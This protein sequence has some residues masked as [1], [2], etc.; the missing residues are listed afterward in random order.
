[1]IMVSPPA[2]VAMEVSRGIQL[3]V[4]RFIRDLLHI[5]PLISGRFGLARRFA[6]AWMLVLAGGPVVAQS[7][8]PNFDS[9]AYGFSYR[10]PPRWHIAPE[11][12]VLPA[13]KQ[14]AEQSAKNPGQVLSIACA[15]VVF[16]AQQGKPPSVIVVAAV[17]FTCY[18][19]AMTAQNLPGFAAGVSDGLK[20]DFNITQPVYGSYALG[21]HNFW[22]ERAV[23]MTN[24]V[25]PSAYTVET[26]CT[27]LKKTAVCWLGLVNGATALRDFENSVVT[28]DGEPPLTLVPIDAFVKKPQ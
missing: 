8:T 5:S 13:V 9:D 25:P 1:M 3:R 14:S 16:S 18:G 15:Q 19:H 27:V 12:S 17:P 7:P 20:Q 22:I 23:G 28:L 26:A 11:Q 24:S 2:A 21:T 4:V 6:C 10:L